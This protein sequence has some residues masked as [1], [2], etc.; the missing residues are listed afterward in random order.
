MDTTQKHAWLIMA[1]GCFQG[2]Q[3]LLQ[4]LDDEHN[5]IYVHIDRKAEGFSPALFDGIVKK[6]NLYFTERIRV[7]WGGYSQVEAELL[8]LR[9]ATRQYHRY[10]HLISGADFP[11]KTQREI[12]DFFEEHDGTEFVRLDDKA[13]L[14]DDVLPR[15]RYYYFFQELTGRT[16][17]VIAGICSQLQKLLLKLQ[18]L[19]GVNRIRNAELTFYKGENWFSI[20]HELAVYVLGKEE[21]IRKL[22]FRGL[23]VDEVFLQTV[24]M[25]SPFQNRIPGNTLRFTDWNRGRPYTFTKEDFQLLISSDRLIARKFD[26]E[27]SPEIVDMLWNHLRS[28]QK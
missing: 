28:I 2:L 3:K 14:E 12:R 16:G 18:R 19:V 7:S 1:H 17:G 8:L 20:T 26:Y 13:D 24:A 9:E 21:M 5:D 15:V 22:C 10:Y 6:A 27:R 25:N 4:A 23:C 11:L